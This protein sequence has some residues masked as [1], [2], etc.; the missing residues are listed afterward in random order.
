MYLTVVVAS[1]LAA[2]GDLTAAIDRHLRGE[3]QRGTFSGS[4]LVARGETVL[5]SAG[6]GF[7]DV[8]RRK[9]VTAE[10]RYYVASIS[11]QFTAAAILKLAE[12]GK[13]RLDD[14]ITRFLGIEVPADKRAIT[15]HHLLSH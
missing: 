10:T 6:Y 13:L 15:I 9:R 2:D 3:E 14:P 11:K 8:S 12:A 1:L 5:F 7:A 4:V